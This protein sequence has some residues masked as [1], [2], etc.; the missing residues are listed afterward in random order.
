MAPDDPPSR[1]RRFGETRSLR[2][3]VTG[4]R[5]SGLAA[6]LR[7]AAPRRA[8]GEV[9]IALVSDARVRALNRRYRGKDYATDV[10]SFPAT[11]SAMERE[12]SA[13]RYLGDIVIATGVARRQARDLGHSLAAEL[14]ILA[15]H[16]LL[17]LLGYDHERDRGR[18]R[19]LEQRLL[20]RSG[21]RDG[22]IE[23]AHA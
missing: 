8:R 16:G 4:A 19:T 15:L 17:H 12:A 9:T 2:V 11:E 5:A 20:R 22:L 7:R 13:E 21:V 18:M 1:G 3:E 14:R 6:W 23:R 10:R